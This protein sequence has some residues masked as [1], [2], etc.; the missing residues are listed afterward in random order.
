M[1]QTFAQAQGAINSQAPL[2]F[3]G[4]T[5]LVQGDKQAVAIPCVCDFTATGTP[6]SG[7]VIDAQNFF[8]KGYLRSVQ[9]IFVDNSQNPEY[10]TISSNQYGL[11]YSLPAGWQ[12]FFPVIGA[13]ASGF[14]LNVSTVGFSAVVTV[15]LLNVVIPPF[16]WSA[17]STYGLQVVNTPTPN[18]CTDMSGTITVGGTAQTISSMLATRQGFLIQNIDTTNT[19]EALWVRFDGNAAAIETPGS[20]GL[21]AGQSI[22]FP[23]GSIQGACINPI[24]VIAATT[25]HKFSAIEWYAV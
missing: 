11:D 9:T 18:S 10:V 5:N 19:G 4:G 8:N 3:A 17:N 25:G 1:S 13:L 7:Y 24:S 2:P 15:T 21:A 20:F 12:G 14:K 22:A 23:G 6:A 16:Q